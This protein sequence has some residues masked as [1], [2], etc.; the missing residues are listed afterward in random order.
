MTP[1]RSPTLTDS[2]HV[3]M[4]EF[5]GHVLEDFKAGD[6]T[7]HQGIQALASVVASIDRGNYGEATNWFEQGRKLM[8]VGR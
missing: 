4:E 7:K 6:I 8:K 1:L 2:D 3:N 5:F